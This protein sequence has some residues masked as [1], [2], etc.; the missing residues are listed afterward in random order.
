MRTQKFHKTLALKKCTVSHLTG[1]EMARLAGGGIASEIK[2]CYT[3]LR[4]LCPDLPPTMAT[5]DQTLANQAYAA[6]VI[7]L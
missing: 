2:Q 6:V 3:I 4:D 5:E 1:K 7:A